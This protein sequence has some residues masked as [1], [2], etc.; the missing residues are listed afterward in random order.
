MLRRRMRAKGVLVLNDHFG[1]FKGATTAGIAHPPR[2][3]A[4]PPS[5]GAS[6]APLA[7][8]VV[9]GGSLRLGFGWLPSRARSTCSSSAWRPATSLVSF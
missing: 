7:G 8:E 1:V 3:T 9:Y 5:C 4:A 6:S 2:H